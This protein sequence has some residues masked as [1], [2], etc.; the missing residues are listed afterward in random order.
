MFAGNAT[1]LIFL[2]R[3][4]YLVLITV[5]SAIALVS[6]GMHYGTY[7]YGNIVYAY[8]IATALATS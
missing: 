6:L 1:V 4:K 3:G 8:L 7:G 2:N 5:I